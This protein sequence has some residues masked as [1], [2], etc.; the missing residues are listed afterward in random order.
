MDSRLEQ[1]ARNEALVRAVN[2]RLEHVDKAAQDGDHSTNDLQ[3]EFLCECGGGGGDVVCD[4][5]V[6]M[7]LEEYEH[8]RLQDDRFAVVPGHENV[9]LEEIVRR[10]DR[11]FVVDKKP[12]AE[13]FVRDDPRGAPSR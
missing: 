10:S 4:A 12:A 13:P 5:R 7:T 1:Q 2:E 11:F 9:A 6:V 8:V 3:F